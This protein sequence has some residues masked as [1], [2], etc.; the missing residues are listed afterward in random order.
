MFVGLLTRQKLLKLHN[1]GDVSDGEVRVF[2]EAVREFYS[3]AASYAL[4]NLPTT[5]EVLQNAQFVHFE[6]RVN[7]T[8]SQVLSFVLR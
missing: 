1:D 2:Y 3:T 6:N 8:V 5:D 4:K 7:S